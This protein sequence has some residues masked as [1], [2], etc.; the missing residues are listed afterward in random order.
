MNHDLEILKMSVE[1]TNP[2]N[3]L[4]YDD[5][6][7]PSVMVRIPKFTI[8]D[9]IEGGSDT[10]HPAFVVDGKIVP[11]IM[12][13]KY[14]NVVIDDRAYSLPGQNPATNVIRDI[15]KESCESKGKGWHLMSNAE[16][17]AIALWCKKNGFMPRG[18]NAFAKDV[19]NTYERGRVTYTYKK[20]GVIKEGITATG[21][22]PVS[23]AHDNSP[24][25][26]YDMNGNVWAQVSGLRIL[27]GEIQVIP[28]N[29]SAKA[30]DETTE[31]KLWRAISIDGT[32]VDPGSSNTFKWDSI[33]GQLKLTVGAINSEDKWSDAYFGDLVSDVPIPEILKV[34]ALYPADGNGYGKQKVWCNNTG[35]RL[36]WRGGTWDAFENSGIFCLFTSYART[37]VSPWMGFR[38]AYVEL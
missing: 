19:Y 32:L 11:E 10:I 35:E 7:K 12:V 31:S 1:S 20:D 23:W 34:L 2:N 9:V 27:N 8:A 36:P 29:N 21:S 30:V 17:A 26:I 14:S 3:T 4:I 15:A 5:K 18:N 16:W 28:D 37:H 33:S 22:G 13:S 6:G 38:S 25:G 24:A